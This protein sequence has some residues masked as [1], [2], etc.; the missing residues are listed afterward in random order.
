M[1]CVYKCGNGKQKKHT[2]QFPNQ[3]L[4]AVLLSICKQSSYL[5]VG[6]DALGIHQFPLRFGELTPGVV[7]ELGNYPQQC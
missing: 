1:G 7:A 4:T 2:S 6:Q 3:G 5:L